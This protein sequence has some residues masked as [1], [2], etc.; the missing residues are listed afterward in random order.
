MLLMIYVKKIFK[1]L[2]TV[3]LFKGRFYV[4]TVHVSNLELLAYTAC[5]HSGGKWASSSSNVF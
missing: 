4:F 3:L 1:I 5:T 2:N